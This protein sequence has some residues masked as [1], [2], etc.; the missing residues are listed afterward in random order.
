MGLRI[1]CTGLGLLLAA[2]LQADTLFRAA[3]I[4]DG[5]GAQPY[6][7]DLRVRG[8]RIAAIGALQP[9]TT[10]T[11]IDAQGL[12][13]A[14]G[15]IDPHSHHDEHLERLPDAAAAVSQ[16][17]TTIVVGVDGESIHPFRDRLPQPVAVNLASFSGHGTLRRA[18]LGEDYR[19]L[20]SA[21]EVAR[22]QQLLQADMDAGALGL[23]TG[24][25]YDPGIYS[26]TAEIVALART[27]AAAGGIYASHMR[28]EDVK[29][30]EAIDELATI[31][32]AA[33]IPAHVSHLKLAL[34]DRWGKAGTVLEKLDALRAE[35]LDITADA[36][37]YTYWHSS[38][39]VLFPARDFSDMEAA[40]QALLHSTPAAGLRLSRYQPEPR[41]VGMTLEQIAA[42]RN[43]A[44]EITLLWLINRAYPDGNLDAAEDVEAVMGT[45][46]RED[47]VA[48]I[49]AWPH[50]SV[51][52]DGALED[53]HPRGAGAFTRYLRDHVLNREPADLAAGI[54][55]MTGKSATQ[56]R[57]RDRGRIGI[58]RYA[59][60]VLFDPH[61]VR[62]RADLD[63]PGALSTGM[64][65]VWVNGERVWD[66]SRSTGALPGQI[67]TRD[68]V[69]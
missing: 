6:T 51:C 16:G 19:R 41:F 21:T 65:G 42:E 2:P 27:A 67:V 14:P 54:H 32:R 7:A 22:M 38:L 53:G 33:K 49:L 25:E 43:E 15:F 60:L 23:S 26:A 1:V 10:D 17:I 68:T 5:S 34:I 35:G 40:R 31:A 36:Y 59:D 8:T 50:T 28:S 56:M 58:G 52:S 11:I 24:L 46:M 66:G 45:S 12:V 69:L 48:A 4:V 9:A 61:T 47:D 55:R 63:N 30:D 44:P 3:S 13:L 18:V 64:H 57:I 39:T 37:P 20:A 29:L 62:D